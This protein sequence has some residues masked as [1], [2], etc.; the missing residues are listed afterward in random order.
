MFRKEP[1][2]KK[3]M[4]SVLV[5]GAFFLFSSLCN[6]CAFIFELKKNVCRLL[7]SSNGEKHE[8]SKL[9]NVIFQKNINKNRRFFYEGRIGG[10]ILPCSRSN[11]THLYFQDKKFMLPSF[12]NKYRRPE[13]NKLQK[14]MFRKKP[15]IKN[16]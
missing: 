16:R 10:F 1:T 14:R 15:T 13:K 7:L 6:T 8:K 9:C 12:L 3:Q 5:K 11:S 4:L 2:I